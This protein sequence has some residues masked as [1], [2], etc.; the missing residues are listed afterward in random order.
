MRLLLAARELTS[1]VGK[2]RVTGLRSIFQG[3]WW[4]RGEEF[5]AADEKISPRSSCVSRLVHNSVIQKL[6]A[7]CFIPGHSGKGPVS[8][9]RAVHPVSYA[10]RVLTG[11][12]DNINGPSHPNATPA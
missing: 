12:G 4:C 5:V 2:R 7:V 11:R 6:R 1:G 10:L 8:V 3:N 9:A